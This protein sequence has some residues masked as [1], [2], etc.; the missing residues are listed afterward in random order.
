MFS[1][2]KEFFRSIL[3]LW[4][5][6]MHLKNVSSTHC[7]PNISL[8]S[9]DIDMNQMTPYPDGVDGMITYV[10]ASGRKVL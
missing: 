1:V 3:T 6:F 7:V 5:S 4:V 8:N 2:Y 9:G 10:A